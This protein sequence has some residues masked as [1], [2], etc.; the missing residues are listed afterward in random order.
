MTVKAVRVLL[1]AV[2]MIKEAVRKIIEAMKLVI[3]AVRGSVEVPARSLGGPIKLAFASIFGKKSIPIDPRLR[4]N[5]LHSRFDPVKFRAIV[6]FAS[7]VF[8]VN[9]IVFFSILQR[10]E[11]S[12]YVFV[13]S[14][15]DFEVCLS[16]FDTTRPYTNYIRF[17]FDPAKSI[18]NS[19]RFASIF[20]SSGVSRLV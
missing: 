4:N 12:H 1:E 17:L 18:N 3:E 19:V 6:R 13:R 15:I 16:C 11:L 2:R 9:H 5:F 7:I 20:P 14:G 8:G 10:F